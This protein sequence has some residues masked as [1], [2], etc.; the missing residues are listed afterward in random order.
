MAENTVKKDKQTMGKLPPQNLE[1]EQSLLGSLLIDKDAIIKVA[2]IVGPEDFYSD[3]HRMIFESII[4]LYGKREPIDL[5]TLANNLEEKEKLED[6]G[7]RSYL[8]SLS[9]MVPTSSHVVN[10]AEIVQKKS[11][12]RSL[13]LDLSSLSILLAL[14]LI[15]STTLLVES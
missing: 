14:L 11:T 4:D 8:V 12:L 1:A 2:D 6:I 10:Y 9:N 15:A 5:L 7:G 3:K 13:V